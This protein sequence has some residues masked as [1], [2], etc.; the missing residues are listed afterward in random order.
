MLLITGGCDSEN[1]SDNNQSSNNENS[2]IESAVPVEAMEVNERII[3]QTL[4]LTGILIPNNSVD[5]VA[6]VLA[7][8]VFEDY[9]LKTVH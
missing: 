1:S 4:E 5:I 2:K 7:N 8:I 3:E 6:E 9:L